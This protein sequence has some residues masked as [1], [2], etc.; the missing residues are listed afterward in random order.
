MN[1]KMVDLQFNGIQGVLNGWV[2][3]NE[4]VFDFDLKPVQES[5]GGGDSGFRVILN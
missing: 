4:V 1:R 3:Q 5:L 2:E